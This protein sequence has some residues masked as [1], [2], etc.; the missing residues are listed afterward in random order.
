MMSCT[1]GAM[2]SLPTAVAMSPIA[3]LARHRRFMNAG[4]VACKTAVKAQLLVDHHF[5][6]IWLTTG[7]SAKP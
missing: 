3:S 2:A 4:S 6:I 7:L 5:Q 1:M